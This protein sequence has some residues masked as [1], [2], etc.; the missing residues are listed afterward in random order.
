MGVRM[1]LQ[2]ARFG[3]ID[4]TVAFHPAEEAGRLSS[5]MAEMFGEMALFLIQEAQVA[6]IPLPALRYAARRYTGRYLRYAA[7]E[8]I[9]RPGPWQRLRLRLRG[10]VAPLA[11]QDF[12]LHTI[13]AVAQSFLLDR[14]MVRKRRAP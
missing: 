9:I 11:N 1:A 10:F 7:R 5:R 6:D 12:A 2:G 3:R 14:E 13:G 8:A 4:V